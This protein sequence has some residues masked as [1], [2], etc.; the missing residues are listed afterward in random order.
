MDLTRSDAKQ[1]A[2]GEDA[3]SAFPVVDQE[4]IFKKHKLVKGMA[5][6]LDLLL[7]RNQ[8][9]INLAVREIRVSR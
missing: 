3:L 2:P 9:H 8:P 5:V 7:M 1:M 4:A 6:G